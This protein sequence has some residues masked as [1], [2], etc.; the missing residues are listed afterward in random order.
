MTNDSRRRLAVWDTSALSRL[1]GPKE[2]DELIAHMR[3][4]HDHWIPRDVLDEIASTSSGVL[5]DRLLHT[6]R[7]LIHRSGKVLLHPA[8]FIRA[9]VL[10]FDAVGLI[11]WEIL[12]ESVPEY[13]QSLSSKVFDDDLA[14]K[15]STRR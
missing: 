10:M 2:H 7:E 1:A 12:L 6:C 14:K 5:R 9:G 4:S 13:Q 3:I 8:D 11:D 15:R